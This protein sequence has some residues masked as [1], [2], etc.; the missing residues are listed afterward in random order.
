[1]RFF[2]NQFLFYWLLLLAPAQ[3][4]TCPVLVIGDSISAAYGLQQ[5]QGWVAL[6]QQN[7]AHENMACTVINASISGDTSSGGLARIDQA[8]RTH[9]PGIVVI[10]LGGNDGLRGLPPNLIKSNL[11]TMIEKSRAAQADVILLGI[12]IPPNYG[13]S[14]TTL[15]E[16]IY[17]DLAREMA[18]EFVPKLLT[19]IGDHAEYMQSDGIHPNPEGQSKIRDQVFEKI[20]N[21]I[22]KSAIE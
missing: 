9:Q 14:Y 6:L 18:V 16:Q 1:M 8:L 15:F 19:G 21:M 13:K 3:G 22:A 17:P 11:K 12:Q 20:S 7:L 10:E 2:K 4:S 5:P